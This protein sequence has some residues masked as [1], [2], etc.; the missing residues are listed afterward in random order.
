MLLL[1]WLF[2][3]LLRLIF[4]HNSTIILW[5][6][7]DLTIT[8]LKLIYRVYSLKGI[9]FKMFKQSSMM[10]IWSLAILIT[11]NHSQ[12]M[13]GMSRNLW[14]R[15]ETLSLQRIKIANLPQLQWKALHL[16]LIEKALWPLSHLKMWIHTKKLR[17]KLLSFGQETSLKMASRGLKWIQWFMILV[18]SWI[19][20]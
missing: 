7:S 10:V 1:I 11:F 3:P 18:S 13:I 19:L 4:L 2:H 20:K 17:F 9:L 16:L 6:S 14:L 5:K 8:K 12:L 15:R